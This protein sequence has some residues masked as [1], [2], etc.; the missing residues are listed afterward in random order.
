M[1]STPLHH[2]YLVAGSPDQCVATVIESVQ[3]LFAE[4]EVTLRVDAA[5]QEV[6]VIDDARE[7]VNRGYQRSH[8]EANCIIRGFNTA[9]TEAQN[10]LLKIT[11]SPAVGTSFFFVTPNPSQLLE[12]IRSR[13][14]YLSL[15]EGAYVDAEITKLA[16]DFLAAKELAERLAIVDK[17]ETRQALNQFIT[18]LSAAPEAREDQHLGQAL[19]DAG[20]WLGDTGA[21]VKLLRQYIAL[22]YRW[23]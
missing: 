5:V 14:H 22:S 15:C 17:I 21:S 10:A 2:A 9:T 3:E 6:L 18:K 12:T 1:L 13:T 19:M 4:E 23:Q 11:E 20:N 8:Q 16:E 7:L